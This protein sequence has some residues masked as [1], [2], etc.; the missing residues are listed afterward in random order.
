MTQ[1]AEDTAIASA[2]AEISASEDNP[3]WEAWTRD[4]MRLQDRLHEMEAQRNMLAS[5]LLR[6]KNPH[7]AEDE[8]GRLLPYEERLAPACGSPPGECD[9]LTGDERLRLRRAAYRARAGV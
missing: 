2:L 4:R 9:E 1:Q 5:K 8:A 7:A 3:E 6:S